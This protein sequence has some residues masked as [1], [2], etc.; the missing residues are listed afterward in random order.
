MTQ[1]NPLLAQEVP[2]PFQEHIG[3]KI[4]DWK[5]DFCSLELPLTPELMNRYGIPHGGL[6][7]TLLDTAMG[8]CCC[9]TEDLKKPKFVATLSL[10]VQYLAKSEGQMLYA[11]AERSGG[12][13]STSF[14][15]GRIIDDNGVL[16]ATGTAVF[17]HRSNTF[18]PNHSERKL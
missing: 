10:N 1:D 11:M 5:Q 16:I 6:H 2:Y 17:K 14:A 18:H 15:Q 8:Y 13:K 9:F 7:A 3:F 12:G 4:T